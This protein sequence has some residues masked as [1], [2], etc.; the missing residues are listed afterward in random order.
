MSRA[1]VKADAS[2]LHRTY[3]SGVS[4]QE[5]WAREYAWDIEQATQRRD[6]A[7]LRQLLHIRRPPYADHDAVWTL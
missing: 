6:R 4:I 2:G 7:A 1:R 5:G 3:V